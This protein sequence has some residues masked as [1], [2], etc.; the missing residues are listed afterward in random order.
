MNKWLKGHY[1]PVNPGKYVGDISDIVYR[2]AWE[3]CAMA[4]FDTTPQI[5]KWSSETTIIPYFDPVSNKERRYFMDFR[6]MVKKQDG[7]LKTILVEIKPF[8][9]TI[10]PRATKRKSE[11]TI[12]TE[13]ATW[14]T[15]KAKWDAAK[16]L[17]KQ[18]GWEFIIITEKELYGGIDTGFKPV[19][20][21]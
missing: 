8:K 7:T 5:T 18:M 6:I 10:M 11:K 19:R 9:Q 12:M 3:R 16:A 4:W 15:N 21:R 1:T 17:C 20:K 13:R 2:S 14:L